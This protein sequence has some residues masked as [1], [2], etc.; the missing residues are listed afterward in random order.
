MNISRQNIA[1]VCNL[2]CNL[3]FDYPTSN[4]TA[5]NHGTMISLTYDN[6]SVPPVK[7][8][9]L[10]YNVQDVYILSPSAI[11]N[12]SL[13][14]VKQ[15]NSLSIVGKISFSILNLLM[16]PS[17]CTPLPYT[18]IGIFFRLQLCNSLLS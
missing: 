10:D 2:K 4:C 13:L 1:G 15:I 12:T 6:G 14:S 16:N 8:N 9:N 11:Y 3:S 7:Y 5:T 17:H 18:L